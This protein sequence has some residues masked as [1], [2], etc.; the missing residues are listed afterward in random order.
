M[1][2]V[3]PSLL[4]SGPSDTPRP[5]MIGLQHI[6][7]GT[8]ASIVTIAVSLIKLKQRLEDSEEQ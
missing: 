5:L 1:G 3:R 4:A 2:N 8:V 7:W 6:D